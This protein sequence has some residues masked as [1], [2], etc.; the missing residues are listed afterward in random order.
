ME[1]ATYASIAAL[2]QS[3]TRGT[4]DPAVPEGEFVPLKLS[5]ISWLWIRLFQA[6]G[7]CNDL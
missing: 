5:F 6:T 4:R 2:A 1:T 7:P 3:A